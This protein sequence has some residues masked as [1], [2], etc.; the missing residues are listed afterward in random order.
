MK[1]KASVMPGLFCCYSSPF[2]AWGL[3]DGSSTDFAEVPC[4]ILQC[5]Q[6]RRQRNK[7]EEIQAGLRR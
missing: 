4:R 7:Y 6:R 1:N 5:E 2:F 3:R